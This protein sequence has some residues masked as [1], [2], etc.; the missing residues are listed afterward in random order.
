M[1][2]VMTGSKGIVE[3]QGTAE[4]EP[5]QRELLDKM[6]DTADAGISQLTEKQKELLGSL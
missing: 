3:I 6:I 2:V 1:N 4:A 5:F